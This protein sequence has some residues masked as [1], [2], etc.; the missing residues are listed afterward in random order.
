MHRWW[1]G[2]RGVVSSF[3]MDKVLNETAENSRAL[4]G[5]HCTAI[6]ADCKPVDLVALVFTEDEHRTMEEWADGPRLFQRS[7]D[8]DGLLRIADVTDHVRAL[9]FSPDRLPRGTSRERRSVTGGQH[10]AT[11]CVVEKEGRAFADADEE[12]PVRFSVQRIAA[13]ANARAC[14]DEQC[15]RVDLE[16][17]VRTSPVGIA[18]FDMATARSAWFSCGAWCVV[19][20]LHAPNRPHE[21]VLSTGRSRDGRCRPADS[22]RPQPRPRADSTAV[23]TMMVNLPPD[24]SLVATRPVA[25]N[26]SP[27]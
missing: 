25:P 12:F 4:A 24:S 16:A 23:G 21:D 19:E 26:G 5:A 8:L 7:R 13:I 27:T 22:L 14:R 10:V 6:D 11:S 3:D 17:R 18:V 20:T 2:P 1:S 15:A 9:G